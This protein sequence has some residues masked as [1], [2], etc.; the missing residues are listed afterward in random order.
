[1]KIHDIS[2]EIKPEMMVYKNSQ[3]K[4][5]IFEN[6]ANY[7]TSD[8]YE[9]DIK[10]NIHTG[11]HIDAPLHMI[12][13]GHT[14]VSYDIERFVSKAKVLDLTHVEDMIKRQ[15]LEKCDIQKDDFLLFKTRNSYDQEFNMAWISLERSGAAYLVEKG[16]VGVGIDALGIERGQADHLTHIQLLSAGI[17]IVEGLQLAEVEAK[18]YELIVLPLKIL[19][20]EGAPARAILIER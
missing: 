12:K 3:K 8:Y 17:M 6:I 2:M 20:L 18:E 19:G 14:M 11:T 9:T 16:V 5:P 10:V 13:D 15:D 7:L 4:V 1:M